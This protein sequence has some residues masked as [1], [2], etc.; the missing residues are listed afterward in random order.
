MEYI[1][2]AGIII[3]LVLF[4]VS[5]LNGIPLTVSSVLLSILLWLFSIGCSGALGFDAM[6]ETYTAGVG[7]ILSKYLF[8]LMFGAWFGNIVAASGIGA[9]MSHKLEGLINHA[10]VK[11]RKVLA[12]S[13]V[14][15][16]NAIF[17]YCGVSV[18]TVVFVVVCVARDLFK[19][20]D[21]PWHLYALSTLG[22]ATFAA[23]MLPG[24]PSNV[25]IAA[26]LMMG[27][28]LS[29]APVLSL[30]LSAE[31][32][33]LAILYMI[34]EVKKVERKKEGFYPSGAEIDKVVFREEDDSYKTINLYIAVPML[35]LPVVLMNIVGMSVPSALLV[36]CVVMT[37]MYWKRFNGNCKQV[38]TVGLTNGIMPAVTLAMTAGFAA[39]LVKTP[40]FNPVFTAISNLDVSPYAKV[41]ILC[42]SMGFLL[43]NAAV[44]ETS[45]LQL[46]G[47]DYLL[48]SGANL[49]VIHRITAMSSMLAIPPHNTGL[50]NSI[51]VAKLTHR[52]TYMHYF[53]CAPVMGVILTVSAL[54]LISLGITY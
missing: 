39:V 17:I 7:N 30:I 21:I 49:E 48:A 31:C 36:T 16:L 13:V 11:A 1:S 51:T 22:S 41:A 19:R 42:G 32:I 27:T 8:L 29:S 20:M 18:Y 38:L 53:M 34:Y 37:A 10:P 14:P 4:V 52:N 33:V 23:C 45:G 2:L 26:G 44:A 50:C 43:G 6:V 25:N 35:F 5:C 24:S 46:I 28:S 3:T 9:A 47:M 15:I 54:L 12:V 40:G